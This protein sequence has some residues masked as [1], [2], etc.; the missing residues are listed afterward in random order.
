[1]PLFTFNTIADYLDAARQMAD[2]GRPALARLLAEEA[3]DRAADPDQ[4][5]RILRDF[6]GLNLRQED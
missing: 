5:A 6:P 2:S 4:A 3:A 1:M